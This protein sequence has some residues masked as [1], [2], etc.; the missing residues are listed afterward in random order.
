MVNKDYIKIDLNIP[1]KSCKNHSVRHNETTE[2][3]IELDFTSILN[4]RAEY[5]EEEQGSTTKSR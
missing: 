1:F 4:D 5:Y 3:Y 2:K